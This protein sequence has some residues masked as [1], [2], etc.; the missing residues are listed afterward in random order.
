MV[1]T[2]KRDLSLH[3]NLYRTVSFTL[4]HSK[5]KISKV[6][7]YVYM[8]ICYRMLLNIMYGIL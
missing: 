3:R 7:R 4:L 1:I 2:H 8:T 5:K 6:L